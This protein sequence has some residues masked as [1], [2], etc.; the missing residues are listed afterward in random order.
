M[1]TCQHGH[2]NLG[3]SFIKKIFEEDYKQKQLN[4]DMWQKVHSVE[5]SIVWESRKQLKSELIVYLKQRLRDE[6][7]KRQENPK[8]ILQTIDSLNPNA[9]TVGFARRFATYKRAKLLFSNIERFGKTCYHQRKAY[10]V[11]LCR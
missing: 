7:T 9:L 10:S 11:Y 1:Y 8:L 4:F 3:S 6:M 2:Q 5:D